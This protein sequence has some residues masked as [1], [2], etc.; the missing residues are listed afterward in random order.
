MKQDP[1]KQDPM[2]QD[3]MEKDPMGR[4]P[5]KQDLMEKDPMRRDPMRRGCFVDDLLRYTHATPPESSGPGR[6]A[7]P[8]AKKG[9]RQESAHITRNT[10]CANKNPQGSTGRGEL[11]ITLHGVMPQSP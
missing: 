7:A 9:G 11:H 2:K 1:M 5:M 3:P 4:D 8:P 6:G 10:G